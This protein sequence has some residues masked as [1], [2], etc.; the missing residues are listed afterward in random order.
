M[1]LLGKSGV[2]HG[3]RPGQR[4]ALAWARRPAA[5]HT[6]AEIRAPRFGRRV[7]L[8]AAD[9]GDEAGAGAHGGE[10]TGGSCGT[11][12]ARASQTRSCLGSPA[13]SRKS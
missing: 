13:S 2:G 1:P 7:F 11:P 6:A 12:L 9:A 8:A 3:S 4:R 5:L 10:G